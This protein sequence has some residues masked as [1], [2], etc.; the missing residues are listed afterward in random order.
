MQ[1]QDTAVVDRVAPAVLLTKVASASP[2]YSGTSVIYTYTA[3]NP[4]DVQLSGVNLVD[5]S[6][7]L[8]P[9]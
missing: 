4:G 6:A 7:T 2:V 8:P 9:L 1:D 3:T 5:D